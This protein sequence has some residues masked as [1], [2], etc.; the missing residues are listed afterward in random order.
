[1]RKVKI[2]LEYR[3]NWYKTSRE[4]VPGEAEIFRIDHHTKRS[5]SIHTIGFKLLNL[6]NFHAAPAEEAPVLINLSTDD[7]LPDHAAIA[8]LATGPRRHFVIDEDMAISSS[9]NNNV[10]TWQVWFVPG[11][12]KL[13]KKA[14]T[15]NEHK[16]AVG[17]ATQGTSVFIKSDT[18]F[19]T[20]PSEFVDFAKMAEVRHG[21]FLTFLSINKPHETY[22]DEYYETYRLC[23]DTHDESDESEENAVAITHDKVVELTECSICLSSMEYPH[24]LN[25]CGHSFCHTCSRKLMD[26]YPKRCPSCRAPF[27]KAFPNYDLNKLL[28][29]DKTFPRSKVIR[30]E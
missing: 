21:D 23:I 6:E 18:P 2:T 12:C 22:P 5:T 9:S 13:D 4:N 29:H 16:R 27:M 17:F 3:G 11:S 28:A 26:Q 8:S 1:M 20:R 15:T 24:M 10:F 25:G 7:S 30:I 19:K 14:K